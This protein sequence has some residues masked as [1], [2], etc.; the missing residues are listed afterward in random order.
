MQIDDA[1]H[2]LAVFGL[3]RSGRRLLR[4][5]AADGTAIVAE[6]HPTD[7]LMPENTRAMGSHPT[8]AHGD[9]AFA[10]VVR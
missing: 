5:P 1:V 9:P 7:G 8:G 2:R 10:Q 6:L 3:W 4:G